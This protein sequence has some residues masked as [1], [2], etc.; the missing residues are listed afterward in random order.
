MWPATG[1][2]PTIEIS[3]DQ[4]AVFCSSGPTWWQFP[5]VAC[6]KCCKHCCLVDLESRR[7]AE[8]F[9]HNAATYLAASGKHCRS[10]AS[11]VSDWIESSHFHFICEPS[12][13]LLHCPCLEFIS[14]S[15]CP[16]L[17]SLGKCDATACH[18][19]YYGWRHAA[20]ALET[21]AAEM[22]ALMDSIRPLEAVWTVSTVKLKSTK[23][24]IQRSTLQLQAAIVVRLGVHVGSSYTCVLL[25]S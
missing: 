7:F 22:L 16:T 21:S 13:A 17:K 18:G 11:C 1:W 9:Q 25:V 10:C 3:Y 24:W 2:N 8:L 4:P 19:N 5:L 15:M 6:P 23:C 12:L 14:P 20:P